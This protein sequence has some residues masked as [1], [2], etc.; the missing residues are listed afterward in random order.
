METQLFY[1]LEEKQLAF[2]LRE[3][4]TADPNLEARFRGFL[5]TTTGDFQCVDEALETPGAV[6]DRACRL[7]IAS[8]SQL[9]QW[10]LIQRPFDA[11]PWRARCS[12]HL[13][14]L[15][16]GPSAPLHPP[17]PSQP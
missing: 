11:A 8:G 2:R 17:A 7:C 14:L 13:H 4:V 5:N 15:Q 12:L 1:T 10:Q 16:T 6:N 3:N 9:H